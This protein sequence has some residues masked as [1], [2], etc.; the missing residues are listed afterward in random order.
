MIHI[1]QIIANYRQRLNVAGK[2]V[3]DMDPFE[4]A[5]HQQMVRLDTVANRV[6]AKWGVDNLVDHAPQAMR[7]KWMRQLE[8]LD[9]AIRDQD[10]P[11]LI[12]LVDG[13]I[14]GYAALE[15]AAEDAGIKPSPGIAWAHVHSSGKKYYVCR[16][17]YDARVLQ[18]D[19][20]L[21]DCEI[22]TLEEMVNVVHEWRYGE[23]VKQKEKITYEDKTASGKPPCDLS[24]GGDDI[25]F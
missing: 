9:D 17:N 22:Y 1:K 16:T 7:E 19:E 23:K 5:V 24:Q 3:E 11:K 15:K 10:L 12:D 18:K 2:R 6:E 21:K 4:D 25:P 14:R 20:G 8:K 13:T